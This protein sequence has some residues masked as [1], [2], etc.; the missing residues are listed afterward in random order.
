M[1]GATATRPMTE[2]R[3]SRQA[4]HEQLPHALAC[5]ASCAAPAHHRPVTPRHG[6]APPAARAACRR[7]GRSPASPKRAGGSLTGEAPGAAPRRESPAMRRRSMNSG[8]GAAAARARATT[9]GRAAGCRYRSSRRAP[10]V[11]GSDLPADEA[12]PASS[13]RVSKCARRRRD[14][15][16]S[17]AAATRACA[18]AHSSWTLRGDARRAA[19]ELGGGRRGDQR[20]RAGSTSTS[21][22][23]SSPPT[24]PPGGCTT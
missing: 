5:A 24:T 23:N 14:R 22:R 6:R 20:M 11:P 18:A 21:M 10:A 1:R 15:R 4:L 9:P 16:C 13:A 2:G 7:A 19:V 17:P 12:A 3:S 8:A